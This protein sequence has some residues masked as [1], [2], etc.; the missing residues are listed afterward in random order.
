MGR[1]SSFSLTRDSLIVCLSRATHLV[2]QGFHR[3]ALQISY[4]ILFHSL[5]LTV[6]FLLS[7]LHPKLSQHLLYESTA[8]NAFPSHSAS[9]H[10]G[11]C[12][13]CVP[14]LSWYYPTIMEGCAAPL[15]LKLCVRVCVY[16]THLGTLRM[17]HCCWHN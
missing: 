14:T 10:S 4:Q 6:L 17:P 13:L 11:K 12:L 16:L 9:A 1:P 3:M 7:V 5:P 15:D 8:G 2:G